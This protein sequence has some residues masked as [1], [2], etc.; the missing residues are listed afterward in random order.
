LSA[1]FE[2]EEVSALRD[3]IWRDGLRAPW[4]GAPLAKLAERVLDVAK[5]G[6]ERRGFKSPRGNDERVHLKRLEELVA[7]AETPADKLLEGIGDTNF[8]AKVIERTELK[9]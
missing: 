2:F 3:R 9:P 6:L 7:R 8:V 4:R 1:D 5:G